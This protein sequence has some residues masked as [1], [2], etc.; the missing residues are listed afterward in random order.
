MLENHHPYQKSTQNQQYIFDRK[1]VTNSILTGQERKKFLKIQ[2]RHKF[3][4]LTPE[5][6]KIMPAVMECS[7]FSEFQVHIIVNNTSF[8][9]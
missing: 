5:I 9:I 3:F 6:F 4:N 8:H 2:T 1:L 7:D